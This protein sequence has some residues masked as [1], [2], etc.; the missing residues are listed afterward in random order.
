MSDNDRLSR[1]EDAIVDLYRIVSQ[2]VDPET[3]P[4]IGNSALQSALVRLRDTA[5]EIL[6]ERRR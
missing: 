5:A 3:A 6:R 2:G 1:L 4:H